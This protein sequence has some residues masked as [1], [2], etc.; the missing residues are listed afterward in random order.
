MSAQLVAKIIDEANKQ[1]MIVWGHAWL[2][3]AKPSDLVKAGVNPISHSALLIHDKIDTIPLLWKN[4]R[5]DDKFWKS[6]IPDFST[7]FQLMKAH[8]TILDATMITYK[9]WG[10]QDTSMRYDYEITKRITTQ[11]YKAGVM[12]DAGTDDD[13]GAFVQKEMEVLVNDAGL[14]NFD[15]LVAATLNGAYAL[16][17]NNTRGTIAVGKIANLVVLNKN[18]S[19][20]IEN[21]ESVF[22]VI[23]NGII[24]KK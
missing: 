9:H 20:K 17:I 19:Q 6:S 2:Q 12:I 18:P 1:G 14:S 7:L 13:Q 3:N 4:Q 23:K 11:A 15:A 16:H 24:F 22:L 21:I 10:E 5:H 8:N